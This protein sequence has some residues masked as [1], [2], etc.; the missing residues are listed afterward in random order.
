MTRQPTK[1][2]RRHR[3][4]SI[5]IE[6]REMDLGSTEEDSEDEFIP[7]KVQQDEETD[8]EQMSSP[9][10]TNTAPTDPNSGQRALRPS[11]PIQP[12]IL[13][14]GNLTLDNYSTVGRQLGRPALEKMLKDPKRKTQNRPPSAVLAEAQ[15]LQGYYSLDKMSLSLAG[16]TSLSTL[17]S[18]L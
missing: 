11:D 4:Q 3:T 6:E 14:C 12:R 7:D 2:T 8:D 13:T 9:P 17:E 5:T 15:A 16:N 18:A 1:T 10:I